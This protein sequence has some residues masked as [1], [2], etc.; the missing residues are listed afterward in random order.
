MGGSRS[1]RLL[2]N[3]I[4]RALLLVTFIFPPACP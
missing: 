1:Y 2:S 4:Q 3:G